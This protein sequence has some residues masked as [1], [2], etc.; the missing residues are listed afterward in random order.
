MYD[1]LRYFALSMI[2]GF[3]VAIFKAIQSKR[4]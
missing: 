1:D 3:G 2:V 4:G